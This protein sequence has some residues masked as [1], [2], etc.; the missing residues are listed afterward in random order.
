MEKIEK[1]YVVDNPHTKDKTIK[2]FELQ[3]GHIIFDELISKGKKH[4]KITVT[5][6]AIE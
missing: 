6:E 5:L 1:E 2:D 4:I 3:L